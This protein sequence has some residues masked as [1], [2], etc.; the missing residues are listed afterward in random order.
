[1]ADIPSAVRFTTR[2]PATV[3]TRPIPGQ[4]TFAGDLPIIKTLA[5]LSSFPLN[6]NDINCIGGELKRTD[7]NQ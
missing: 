7:R 5:A 2:F 1:M 4:G 3:L 6:P